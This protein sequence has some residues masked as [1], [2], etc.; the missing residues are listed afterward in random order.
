VALQ[1]LLLQV[2]HVLVGHLQVVLEAL[3]L[4]GVE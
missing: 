4:L 1:Q 2:G 3:D